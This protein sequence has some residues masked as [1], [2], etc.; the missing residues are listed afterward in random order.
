MRPVNILMFC[1]TSFSFHN[2]FLFSQTRELADDQLHLQGVVEAHL[3]NLEGW[4]TLDVLV[5]FDAVG[6]GK[7]YDEDGG[8]IGP[9]GL[10]VEVNKKGVIRLIV[11]FENDR[12]V[13][14]NRK[15][16]EIQIFDSLDKEF[17]EPIC[18]S[19][20]RIAVMDKTRAVGLG[21]SKSGRESQMKEIP[22][23]ES[24]LREYSVPNL[25]AFGTGYSL[26]SWRSQV[27][28]DSL[29]YQYQ[30]DYISSISHTGKDRYQ[31]RLV[32]K[33]T[34]DD[35]DDQSQ[36]F[37]DWNLVDNVPIRYVSYIRKSSPKPYT[38]ESVEWKKVGGVA[39]PHA[40]R[41]SSSSPIAF[42]NGLKFY[43]EYEQTT[44]LHWFSFNEELADEL[45]DPNLLK[46]RAKVDELLSDSVFEKK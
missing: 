18:D 22:P 44:D 21:H 8:V 40:S 4:Q 43:V 17:G 20:D 25:K 14:L 35:S 2:E 36:V 19:D 45:F 34:N 12:A 10:T 32:G 9:D 27:V 38:T 31:V 5:R 24:L 13:I 30:P 39:L 11:D 41:H 37:A 42:D 23:V 28:V 46:D 6:N 29:K 3:A 15:Q 7:R 33:P 26:D 16:Q 1:L